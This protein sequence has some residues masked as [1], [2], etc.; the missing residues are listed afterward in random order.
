VTEDRVGVGLVGA[1]AMS[2]D[3]I[4][5][6]QPARRENCCGAVQTRVDSLHSGE[7]VR[8]GV[9]DRPVLYAAGSAE[10]GTP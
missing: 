10:R 7:R 6:P 9:A 5:D 8:V 3:Q 4:R 2:A 1:G